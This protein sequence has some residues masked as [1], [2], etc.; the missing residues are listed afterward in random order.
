MQSPYFIGARTPQQGPPCG[1]RFAIEVLTVL[2]GP[3]DVS[4]G[5]R[6]DHRKF[7]IAPEKW[8]L[9]DYSPL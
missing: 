7:N 1:W 8:W 6:V 4:G 2:A 3:A 9:E 5:L